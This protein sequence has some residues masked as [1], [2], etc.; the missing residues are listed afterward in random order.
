MNISTDR[1][2]M[3]FKNDRGSYSVGI[4][5][6]NQNGEYENAYFPIQFKK[7][8]ELQNRTL[9]NIKQ[10]KLSFY[11]WE[12]EGKSGRT[13]FIM[14]FEFEKAN[15]E[16]KTD[17]DKKTTSKEERDPYEEFGKETGNLPF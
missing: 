1:P 3:V 16:E 4:S 8:V 5:K 7:D 12:Y 6:K 2:I 17:K 14:C 11:D 9:I 15:K 10:A 13:Y